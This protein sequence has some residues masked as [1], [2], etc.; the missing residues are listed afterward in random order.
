MTNGN[1]T[2]SVRRGIRFRELAIQLLYVVVVVVGGCCRETSSARASFSIEKP[3]KKTERRDFQSYIKPALAY[4]KST[5]LLLIF[6]TTF[7]IVIII[8]GNEMIIGRYALIMTTYGKHNIHTWARARTPRKQCT[9]I[10]LSLTDA[11]CG[12]RSTLPTDRNEFECRTNGHTAVVLVFEDRKTRSLERDRFSDLLKKHSKSPIHKPHG[13]LSYRIL[14]KTEETIGIRWGI[15]II[16]TNLIFFEQM[17]ATT[18][19]TMIRC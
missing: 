16:K 14:L 7:Y 13:Q 19:C 15:K 6:N 2:N 5:T 8:I 17:R 10:I 4:A 1:F 18:A 9:I 12:P 11:R 3:E